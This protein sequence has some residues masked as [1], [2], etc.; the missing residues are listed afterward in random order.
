M[1]GTLPTAELVVLAGSGHA[2]TVEAPDDV[3]RE[4]R[5]FLRAVEQPSV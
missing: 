5:R 3:T 4:L 1:H 2:S